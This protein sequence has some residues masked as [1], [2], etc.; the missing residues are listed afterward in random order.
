[1]D[2]FTNTSGT[3]A[4]FSGQQKLPVFN[5]K[6]FNNDLWFKTGKEF[7]RNMIA[8]KADHQLRRDRDRYLRKLRGHKAAHKAKKAARKAKKAAAAAAA[9]APNKAIPNPLVSSYSDAEGL[10]RAR[11][12]LPQD[13]PRQIFS[14]DSLEAR[15]R[16]YG[17]DPRTHE[18]VKDNAFKNSTFM[19]TIDLRDEPFTNP[20]GEMIRRGAVW[21]ANEVPNQVL[22]RALHVN[23]QIW[24]EMVGNIFRAKDQLEDL[25]NDCR[26]IASLHVEVIGSGSK[27]VAQEIVDWLKKE[28]HL[29]AARKPR[30]QPTYSASRYDEEE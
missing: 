14:A 30:L 3:N 10:M 12:L 28:Q 24:A 25:V 22:Y 23:V 4:T 17:Y 16:W 26:R 11:Q 15:C 29:W 7:T 8:K 5:L 27:H 9:A 21:D 1:M 20:D 19:T 2:S 6:T 13:A 18:L